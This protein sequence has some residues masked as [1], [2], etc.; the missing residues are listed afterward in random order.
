MRSST[1]SP[2]R[3]AGRGALVACVAKALRK[4]QSERYQSMNDLAADLRHLERATASALVPPAQARGGKRAALAAG[5]L[6][7][8]GALAWVGWRGAHPAANA[9]IAAGERRSLAVLPFTEL[10]T[11]IDNG[12]GADLGASPADA[13]FSAGLHRDV[14]THRS[15]IGPS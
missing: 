11:D 8:L 5:T 13:S 9:L 15:R 14:L 12:R 7:A 4:E 6:L 3:S 1:A 2:I 10:G